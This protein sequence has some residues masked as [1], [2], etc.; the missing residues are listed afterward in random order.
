MGRYLSEIC[1]ITGDF[2]VHFMR[3]TS[4]TVQEPPSRHVDVRAGWHMAA[5]RWVSR[6]RLLGRGGIWDR[7]GDARPG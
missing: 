3:E 5:V 1:K 6:S 4:E 2:R 7:G